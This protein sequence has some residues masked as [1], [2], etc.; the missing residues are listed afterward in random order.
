MK[1]R[2]LLLIDFQKGI[3]SPTQQLYRLPAVLDKVNQRIAVYRQHHAPIIFVQH[4]ET[5][6]PFDSDSWQLFEK[7]DA[8]PTDFFIR[9]THANAF[10]QTTLE[11]AG[12]QTEFCV[13]TTIR[14][15]HGLGYTCLMT[16]KTTSTLDNGHLT[17]AQIIQ[18][19]EAIW[20]GRFLTFLSL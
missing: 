13:D 3:E 12:V 14:M 4:E 5:E 1:N 6:L 20:A 9:K 10:Y 18:H 15:A 16:P 11:I 7:L 19:H 8:Q 17:A 2:A